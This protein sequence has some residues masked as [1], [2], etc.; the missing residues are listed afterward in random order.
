MPRVGEVD[1]AR[2]DGVRSDALFGGPNASA[3]PSLEAPAPWSLSGVGCTPWFTQCLR[4]CRPHGPLASSDP[5]EPWEETRL[6]HE[7]HRIAYSYCPRSANGGPNAYVIVM[8]LGGGMENPQITHEI[9]L[10]V[11]CH[12]TAQRRP[13]LHDPN[14]LTDFE[15]PLQPVILQKT[16]ASG[17]GVHENVRAKAPRIELRIGAYQGV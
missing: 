5:L 14:A 17:C 16:L 9:G 8:V 11:R 3:P 15:G 6:P 2:R 1:G 13:H 10:T 4:A 12:D 7:Y